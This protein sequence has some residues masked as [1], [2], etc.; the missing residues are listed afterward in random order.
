MAP[1]IANSAAA[2]KAA[3]KKAKRKASQQAGKTNEAVATSSQIDKDVPVPRFSHG[4][5]ENTALPEGYVEHKFE[6]KEADAHKTWDEDDI[7]LLLYTTQPPINVGTTLADFPDGWTEC[8][9]SPPLK[10]TILETPGYPARIKRPD[11]PAHCISESPGKGLGIFATRKVTAGALILAERALMIAPAGVRGSPGIFEKYSAEQARQTVL[12]E[13]EKQLEVAY[14]R[15]PEE[16]QKA[17]IALYNSHTQDGSGPI[18]GVMRTNAYGLGSRLEDKWLGA[19]GAAYTGVFNELSRLN[20]S[21]RPNTY[22]TF[23]MVSFAMEIRALRDI[24]EGEELTTSYSDLLVPTATRQEQLEPYGV[25]CDCESCSNPRVS[26]D[27]RMEITKKCK[28]DILADRFSRWSMNPRLS[29]DFA[30]REG[31]RLLK[32]VEDEGLE[33]D[34]CYSE[35]LLHL[36]MVHAALGNTKETGQYTV[37]WINAHVARGRSSEDLFEEIQTLKQTLT[38]FTGCRVRLRQDGSGELNR[39]AGKLREMKV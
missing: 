34:I 11:T 9:V 23:D 30:L 20:H 16:H 15:M 26:D 38:I 22:R 14:K 36:T 28:G 29:D 7:N 3:A 33:T 8:I 5:V 12:F 21:C 1:K 6:L 31:E 25:R 39:L 18:M 35:L 32:L 17:F 13:W 4:V 10:S 19:V 24:E 27:R 37:R 2:K